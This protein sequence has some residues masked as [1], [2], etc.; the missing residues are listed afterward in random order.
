MRAAVLS[1]LVCSSFAMPGQA[2]D[3]GALVEETWSYFQKY[4]G[5]MMRDPERYLAEIQSAAASY[6]SAANT[7][8]GQV[9]SIQRYEGNVVEQSQ[10]AAVGGKW[11]R[12]CAVDTILPGEVM[13]DPTLPGRL[14]QA[15][16]A[17]LVRHSEVTVTGGLVRQPMHYPG[18]P[19]PVVEDV[20]WYAVSGAHPGMN[21]ISG[22]RIGA[23]FHIAIAAVG[24]TDNTN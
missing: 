24:G 9:L 11:L 8:D 7:P 3:A 18:M 21:T 2:Q 12:T 6:N 5:L 13:V 23:G 15:F 10:V 17:F 4:C 22:V 16:Q 1:I 20:Y 19:A 14:D